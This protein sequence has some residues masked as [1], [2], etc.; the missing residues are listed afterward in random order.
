MVIV[1]DAWG[2]ETWFRLFPRVVASALTD[3]SLEVV[4]ND[5]LL[6]LVTVAATD[7]ACLMYVL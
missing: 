1:C 3:C 2:S 5:F 7:S 4:V 6:T